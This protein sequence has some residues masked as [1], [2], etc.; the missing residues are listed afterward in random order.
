MYVIKLLCRKIK[1]NPRTAA[2]I[3]SLQVESFQFIGA[4][5]VASVVAAYSR[6]HSF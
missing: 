5:S 4:G 6:K 3:L 2:H 1:R